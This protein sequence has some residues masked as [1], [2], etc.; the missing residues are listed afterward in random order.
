MTIVEIVEKAKNLWASRCAVYLLERGD[1]GTCVM[2]ARIV[3]KGTEKY[4]DSKG[5]EVVLITPGEV[6]RAQGASVWESSVDE[7]I[8]FFKEHNV[9]AVYM[10]GWMD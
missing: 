4:L 7:V 8:A 5:D 2:G 3:L 10:P 1:Q 9:N 6:T